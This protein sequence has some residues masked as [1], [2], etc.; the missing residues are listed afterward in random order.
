MRCFA[1]SLHIELR[2]DAPYE[3]GCCIGELRLIFDVS[4]NQFGDTLGDT[5]VQ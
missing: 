1:A 2:T 5:I 4:R 3:F